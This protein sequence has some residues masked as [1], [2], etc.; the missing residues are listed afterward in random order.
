M[1]ARI[2][3]VWNRVAQT[4]AKMLQ[5]KALDNPV[6]DAIGLDEILGV[7]LAVHLSS[8]HVVTMVE[9]LK[10]AHQAIQEQTI[11]MVVAT[12][13]VLTCD[14]FLATQSHQSGKRVPL[15]KYHGVLLP[16]MEVVIRT[17][18]VASRPTT[19]SSPRNVSSKLH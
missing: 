19:M 16:T 12:V 9:I 5:I 2:T 8:A 1:L 14:I 18:F 13:M 15:R 3:L 6:R 11:A 4:S 7:L 10:D 17:D